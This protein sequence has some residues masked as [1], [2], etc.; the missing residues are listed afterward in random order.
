M[1]FQQVDEET[2]LL[3]SEQLRK[4]RTPLPWGQF[5]IILFLQLSEPLTSQ[6]ISPFAP[7][8]IRDI[9]ITNGDEARVGYYVGLLHSLFFA[10]EALTVLHWS[11]VSDHI[12]RKPVIILGMFGLSI[13]MFCFGLSK[14]FWGLVLSRCLNGALNGNIGVMKSLVAEIT[15]STNMPHAY[16]Y[17]PMAWSTGGALGPLIG[18]TLERPAERFPNIFGQSAFFKTYPYFLPC[19]IPAIFSM[20]CLFVSLFFLKETVPSPL[21]FGR[22]INRCHPQRNDSPHNSETAPKPALLEA[23]SHSSPNDGTPLPLRALLTPQVLIAAS[24]YATTSLMDIAFRTI[25]PVFFATPIALGGLGL[26]PPV[27]GKIL[28]S[29]GILNG[30]FQVFCFA[31][32]HAWLG[33]K[34][35]YILGVVAAIPM[36]MTF[37]VI[38]LLVQSQGLNITVWFVIGLQVFLSVVLCISYGAVFIYIN[39]AAPNRASLGA[40]N[41]I[42][43]LVVSIMRAIGPAAVNSTW[44]LCLEKHY[45]GGWL[46]Y[47]LM[48]SMVLLALGSGMLLPKNVWKN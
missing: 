41:G 5:S 14:T 20:V 28:A 34:G 18:G 37:P 31:R 1:P 33:T 15:D 25:Q 48:V 17:L 11:R 32:L 38:S 30:L 23:L 10:T 44:S 9:G 43:Q 6:V 2:P 7:Q 3:V 4:S 13:S 22:I 35:T 46:V 47:Y 19:A 12:G 26:T 27:I 8:L 39:G 16:A 29:F 21:R 42:A 24:T 36:M 45:L 40:T